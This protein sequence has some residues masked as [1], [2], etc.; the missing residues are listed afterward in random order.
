M[1]R[2]DEL[3]RRVIAPL[4]ALRH[5]KLSSGQAWAQ[6]VYD[7]LEQISLPECLKRRAGELCAA[8][9]LREAEEYRQVWQLSLIHIF[10]LWDKS[11]TPAV[12]PKLT[13]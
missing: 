6:A 1:A 4:E 3:R 2:L 9:E 5:R 12:P 10:P 8:G 7:F 11:L 13:M